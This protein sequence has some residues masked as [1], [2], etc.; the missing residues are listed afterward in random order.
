M[1]T[2]I[3]HNF[4]IEATIMSGIAIVLM[5]ILRKTLRRQ[6]GNRALCF[7]WLLVAV[8]LLLPIS[9]SNPLIH[10]IRSP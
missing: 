4:L 10:S 7:G 8:R 9:I 1:R 3:L 2:A 6:L 5:M